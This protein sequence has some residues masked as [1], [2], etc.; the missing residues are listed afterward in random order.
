MNN[1]EN[2]KIKNL[3]VVALVLDTLSLYSLINQFIKHRDKKIALS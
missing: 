2:K 3:R 1:L